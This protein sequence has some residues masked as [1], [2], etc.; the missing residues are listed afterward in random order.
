MTDQVQ[1]AF[2]SARDLSMQ[3]IS[4]AI[5]VVTASMAFMKDIIASAPRSAINSLR[6]AWILYFLSTICGIWTMMAIT[7][8]L[9]TNSSPAIPF[10][11]NIRIPASIQITLFIF[12]SFFMLIFASKSMI[13]KD[14]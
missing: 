11:S 8:S 13:S 7:G 6:Y 1:A 10:S 14:K 4:L 12:A 9:A 3:L 2:S 5:G